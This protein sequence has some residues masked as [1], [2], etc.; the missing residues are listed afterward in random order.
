MQ[1]P[2]PPDPA[3][4]M[5]LEQL[6]KVLE[7]E[8]RLRFSDR[9]VMGGLD[10]FLKRWALEAHRNVHHP[11][12]RNSLRRLG[13]I[14]PDYAGMAPGER[15]AWVRK[16]LRWSAGLDGP[17]G[18][19]TEATQGVEKR[20]PVPPVLGPGQTLD[21]PIQAVTGPPADVLSKLG[22]LGIGTVRD[23]LYFF[24]RRHIDFTSTQPIRSLEVGKEQTAIGTV[25]EAKQ[26]RMGPGRRA[27]T[28]ATLGDETGNVRA[29]WFNQPY[30]ASVLRRGTQ[31]ALSGR[32]GT[33]RG[34]KVFENP[35]HEVVG[36]KELLHTAR[37]VPV[38]PLTGG[39]TSRRL[40][41]I[42][43]RVVDG[44][45]GLLADFLPQGM[46]QRL[47]LLELPQAVREAHFPATLESKDHARRRLAFDE[48][49]LIQLGVLGRK[50]SWKEGVSGHPLRA[51]P[52]LLE[53]FIRSLPFEL[54]G[55][56]R[57]AIGEVAADLGQSAPMS[58]LLQGEVGSGK[59]VVAM[60]AMLVAASNG[61]QAAFMAPTELLAEQHFRTICQ[62]MSG[63][64]KPV[65]AREFVSFSLDPHPQPITTGLL[66][67]SV[68]RKRKQE[69]L[70]LVAH[71]EIGI[72][73]GTHALFQKEVEFV[74]LAL[75][76]VDEQHRF[77]VMQ[78]TELRQKGYNPHLLA[79]TAT[80]IPR[81]LSLTLYGDLDISVL[82]ELPPGRQQVRTRWLDAFQRE[83]AY[84][85]IRKQ[86][87]EGRQA[88]IIYPLI[89]ESEK[90]EVAAATQEH[91]RLSLQVFPD[92]RL[93][94]L[95]GR[96]KGPE[97]EQVMHRFR[98]GELDVLVSTPVVEVGID[99]PNATVMMVEEADRFGLA[100]LHQF[101]GR[102][103]RGE[104]PSY[105]ILLSEAP[106]PEA[107]ERLQLVE[108][109]HD[110]FALAEEDLRLRGP[111]EFFGTRQSGVPDLRMARL[112]DLPLLELAREEATML[113]RED[114]GLE[115]PEHAR[116]GEEVA[117]AWRHRTLAVGE[118]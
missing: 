116:L 96:M 79:M 73:V 4:V 50:R 105:C 114:P 56:Q 5:R 16:V 92:L 55:A 69:L 28:E 18:V 44:C 54:T 101:R 88:F 103:G 109:T 48:L 42:V 47:G 94:L 70:E 52:Q 93:G 14:E 75:A 23:L 11:M 85:F 80:P 6:R 31:I 95:H 37:L 111:G 71:G 77:G 46:G 13:L 112:S 8:Q 35:E 84:R 7:Q 106:S 97:K 41:A 51:D 19:A 58:R 40:R 110:G 118:A 91:E 45:A 83:Q 104:H 49:F 29:I 78:R 89:D 3:R 76:I 34:Q 53:D 60:A 26:V 39:L 81:S 38:Y 100:Q 66:T 57:R 2:L 9:A 43:K 68:S 108:R 86:V 25:W 62:L 87:A 74:N 102:V 20:R 64:A 115:R 61:Q 22:R 72:L 21:S 99:I 65:E 63:V 117:R 82:D 36:S 98:A 24:P 67:G 15:A 27:A 90:L 32:V 30:M 113:F 107:S 17:A 10:E 59:T 33:F 1:E 12:V